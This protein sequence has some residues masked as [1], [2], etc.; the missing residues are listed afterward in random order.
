MIDQPLAGVRVLDLGQGVAAPYCGLLLAQYGA[1]VVKVEPL[2]GDWMRG[3]GEARGD[4]TAYSITYNWG[5]SGIAVDLKDPRGLEVVRRIAGRSDVVL[6]NFRPGVVDRLGIGFEDVRA[7]SPKVLYV[8]ISGFGQTGPYVKRPGSDT[9]LQAFSGLVSLNQDKDGR[10][11]KVG[12]TMVDALTGICAFQAVSMALFGGVT[13]ARLLDV[14]LMQSVA[15]LMTPNIAN[16]HLSGGA[17]PALNAPA[18]T[19][20]TSDGWIAVSLVKEENFRQLAGVLGLLELADDPRFT[21]FQLRA[22]NLPALIDILQDQFFTATTIEWA[23]RCAGAGL[24]ANPVNDC[25]DWLEDPQVKATNAYDMLE[26]P[27]VG[28]VPMPQLPGG[29]PFRGVSPRIG[30]NTRA[31]LREHGYGDDEIASLLD[32]GVVIEPTAAA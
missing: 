22:E 6:E 12:T 5:K 23:E 15:L 14:S 19:Y 30:D 24:L 13:D 32:A 4:H 11:H 20:Q 27:G 26:Q 25:G 28:N 29:L 1:E 17:A 18:G 7:L 9:V 16:F 2:N 10:P 8:S 21:S 3:L 31:V